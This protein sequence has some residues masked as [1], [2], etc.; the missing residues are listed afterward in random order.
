MVWKYNP[1]SGELDYTMGPGTGTASIEFATDSGSANPSGAGVLT[2]AGGTGI[3]TSGSSSTVTINLDDPV[4][5]DNGGTGRTSLTDGAILV[6]DGTNAVEQIGPLTDGQLLIGDT[7]GVSP[8]AATLTA[9]AG[10]SIVNGAGSITISASAGGFTWNEETGTAANMAV[11]NGY[12][13]N[14]ASL[15]TL[16][17]PATAALGEVVQ[18][19]GK[20]AG[21]FKIGQNAGQTIHYI[22]SDTTTGTG[23]S[24]TA[25][26]QYAAIELVCITAN[27]DWAVLDSAGNFTVV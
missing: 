5:V 12:I 24:L 1:F 11:Q 18:V 27:T 20:G 3:N 7:A 17:L 16:T 15:V 13:A 2:V 26:E 19:V 8:A 6:G 21:L 14:N 9:G 25:I 10:V 22:N 23:G 4:I